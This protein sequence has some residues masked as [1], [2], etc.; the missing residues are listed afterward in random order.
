M[1]YIA[2]LSPS[3][4]LGVAT[5]PTDSAVSATR[6][7]FLLSTSAAPLY[8]EIFDQWE[9]RAG[10]AALYRLTTSEGGAGSSSSAGSQGAEHFIQVSG[11]NRPSA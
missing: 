8:Q 9:E 7:R 3:L 5:H 11:P 4:T 2:P 6:L 1:L 10:Q